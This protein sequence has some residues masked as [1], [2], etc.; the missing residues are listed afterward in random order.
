MIYFYTIMATITAGLLLGVAE[1][2]RPISVWK[3]IGLAAIWPAVWIGFL[4]Y[5]LVQWSKK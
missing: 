1:E 4:V 3:L 2:Q 5:L